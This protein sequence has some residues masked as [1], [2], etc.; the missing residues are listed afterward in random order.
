MLFFL[1]QLAEFRFVAPP[2]LKLD[3]KIQY[4]QKL[5]QVHA[6]LKF[7]H[8]YKLLRFYIIYKFALF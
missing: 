2:K 8:V 6:I 5:N 4:D 1:I 7:K 3:K